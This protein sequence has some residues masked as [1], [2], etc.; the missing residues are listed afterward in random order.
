M[1]RKEDEAKKASE[2]AR[3]REEG[4]RLAEQKRKE[5]EQRR[6]DQ[7]AREKQ[8]V[9]QTASTDTEQKLSGLKRMYDGGLLTETEYQ[10][11]KAF[12]LQKFLGLSTTAST[13]PAADQDETLWASIKDSRK[14][15]DIQTF[16][17]RNP[18][19]EHGAE[20]KA[21]LKV[22]KKFASISDIQF[23]NYH[24]LVIGNND[25]KHLPKLKTAV[26]DAN[27]VA[28]ILEKEYGF[29]VTLMLNAGQLDIVD[30]FDELRETLNYDDNLLT[31][32]L[33][34]AR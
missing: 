19:G 3:K 33:D 15:V 13:Q 23:G 11:Q 31:I 16:L 27:A 7:K 21:K 29:E 10:K 12:L 22:L 8:V 9:T 4:Q 25:Y 20:A 1:K 14:I 2:L 6:A 28:A 18:V 17:S 30:A 24:A 34:M 26:G 32:T 5:E